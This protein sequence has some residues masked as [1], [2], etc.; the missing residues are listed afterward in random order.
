MRLPWQTADDI[1][2]DCV[3]G[4]HLERVRPR[5]AILCEGDHWLDVLDPCIGLGGRDE[6]RVV[7]RRDTIARYTESRAP[8]RKHANGAS[9]IG[10]IRITDAMQRRYGRCASRATEHA[11][12]LVQHRLPGTFDRLVRKRRSAGHHPRA[13][14]GGTGVGTGAGADGRQA[15]EEEAE[16]AGEGGD[17]ESTR[18]GP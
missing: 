12:N 13:D 5:H 16:H 8:R 17:S 6:L 14:A 1:V 2:D 18:R 9:G 11:G 10:R 7:N 4:E 15:E 3:P